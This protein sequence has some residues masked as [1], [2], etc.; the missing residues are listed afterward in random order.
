MQ[1]HLS[2]EHNEEL[3]S[4]LKRFLLASNKTDERAKK[5]QKT[6]T[7]APINRD[8]QCPFLVRVFLKENQEFRYSSICDV[9]YM[10]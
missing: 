6:T 3:P 2:E 7:R 5:R 4:D 9:A 1:L 8:Q 10:W